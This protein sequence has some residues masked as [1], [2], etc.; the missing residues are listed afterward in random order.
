MFI[1]TFSRSFPPLLFLFGLWAKAGGV[2]KGGR[3]VPPSYE[4]CVQ[5]TGECVRVSAV[6][7]PLL[8]I[9]FSRSVPNL[10]PPPPLAIPS[11]P[12][13]AVLKLCRGEREGALSGRIHK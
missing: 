2:W 1:E 12:F 3:R 10:P 5:Y 4:I 8:W 6:K 7:W 11:F 13:L 9:P